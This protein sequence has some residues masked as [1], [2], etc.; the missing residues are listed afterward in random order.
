MLA[1]IGNLYAVHYAV[2]F[3][4]KKVSMLLSIILF[5]EK[6]HRSLKL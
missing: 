5:P 2:F 4:T 3:R 6:K 1:N